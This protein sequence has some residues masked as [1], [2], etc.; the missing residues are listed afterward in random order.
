MCAMCASH[1]HNI[2][3]FSRIGPRHE[4]ADSPTGF[5]VRTKGFALYNAIE[6]LSPENGLE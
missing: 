4:S 6:T 5:E 2:R 3:R 1:I